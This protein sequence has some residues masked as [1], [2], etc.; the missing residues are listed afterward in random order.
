[1]RVRDSSLYI[2][3]SIQ[4]TRLQCIMLKIESTAS[5]SKVKRI[6]RTI[7]ESLARDPRIKSSVIYYDVDPA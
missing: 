2:L 7:Y 3:R 1:M 4:E 5:M 6:L